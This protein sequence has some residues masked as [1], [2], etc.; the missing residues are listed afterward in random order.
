MDVL[1]IV[2]VVAVV[3]IGLLAGIFLGHRTGVLCPS[4]AQPIELRAVSAG[5]PCHSSIA[6]SARYVHPSEDAVLEAMERLG[7]HN[8]G[9][10][11]KLVLVGKSGDPL[12]TE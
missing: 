1:T 4:E 5:C 2:R 11:P 9:H 10:S 6:I 7:G 12:L 3:C 8:S